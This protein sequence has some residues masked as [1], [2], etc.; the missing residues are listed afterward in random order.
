MCTYTLLLLH[1]SILKAL[2]IAHT[3]DLGFDFYTRDLCF[4][5][6]LYPKYGIICHTKNRH[7]TNLPID[8]SIAFKQRKKN[9]SL[10]KFQVIP[11]LL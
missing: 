11:L 9:F 5:L 10:L 6:F 4:I 8:D 7:V 2:I 1:S 3:R